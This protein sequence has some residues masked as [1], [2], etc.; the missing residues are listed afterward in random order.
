MVVDEVRKCHKG[1]NVMGVENSFSA[2]LAQRL[3]GQ[4]G[5]VWLPRGARRDDGARGPLWSL[6]VSPLPAWDPSAAAKGEMCC[7]WAGPGGEGSLALQPLSAAWLSLEPDSY[8]LVLQP[9]LG[10]RNVGASGDVGTLLSFSHEDLYLCVRVCS[11]TCADTC[12]CTPASVSS[13]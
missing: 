10:V 11:C 6:T 3:P 1:A 5:H 13:A 8:R 4:L 2:S 12:V 9:S 7:W